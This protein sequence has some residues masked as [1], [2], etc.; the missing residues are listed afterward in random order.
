MIFFETASLRCLCFVSAMFLNSNQ[1][2]TLPVIKS[3]RPTNRIKIKAITIKAYQQ[4]Q[5]K[6]FIKKP[7][8]HWHY[9]AYWLERLKLLTFCNRREKGAG[10]F[11]FVSMSG[12]HLLL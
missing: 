6:G 1:R 4:R 11:K 5:E 7:Y 2:T 9:R 12:A 3:A 8:E 10:R